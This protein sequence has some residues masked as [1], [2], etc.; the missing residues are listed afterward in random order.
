MLWRCGIKF[1]RVV[2]RGERE[3]SGIPLVVGS[4]THA[5][6]AKNLTN[7]IEKGTLLTREAVQDYAR[8]NFIQEW[9]KV[10]VVLTEE[11][12]DAGLE[13]TKGMAQDQTIDLSLAYHYGIAPKI[14]PNRIERP[15]VLEAQGYPFDLS[16]KWDVDEDY[17]K[18][19]NGGD[20]T[21]IINIRD[22]KT[23]KTNPGQI[24]VATSD[25]YTLY[26]MAKFT[27]DGVMPN[28]VIQDT[29]IKPT[30]TRE[31]LAISYR[32]TRTKEDFQIF[33]HRFELACKIVEKGIFTPAN[34]YGFDSP[35]P[36]CGFFLD[37]SCK[38]VNSKRILA[39]QKKEETHG[40]KTKSSGDLIAGLES[41]LGIGG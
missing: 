1:E 38:Y 26:S 28:E 31:A 27:L 37:G 13:A 9:Q 19:S 5:T 20:P 12:K 36:Y 41:A 3:P 2:I 18:Q 17:Y 15:W 33:F 32:S 21:R 22:T 7:K 29:L 10:P 8:D 6:A 16:G 34:S 24:E 30:K 35:C 14:I 39:I 4:A 40:S 11:E 23:R 25:Q